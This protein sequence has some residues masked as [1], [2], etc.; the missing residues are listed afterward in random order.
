MGSNTAGRISPFSLSWGSQGPR[1]AF[2]T[3]C[4]KTGPCLLLPPWEYIIPQPLWCSA[5]PSFSFSLLTSMWIF[6]LPETSYVLPYWKFLS[7]TTVSPVL[8]KAPLYCCFS[9]ALFSTLVPFSATH[10]SLQVST[11]CSL[12]GVAVSSPVSTLPGPSTL[13]FGGSRLSPL[14]R[15]EDFQGSLIVECDML[16]ISKFMTT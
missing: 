5:L 15:F 8:H 12:L 3:D 14:T 13:F 2:I 10:R 16:S 4:L 6:L 9:P 1:A 11:D 7:M